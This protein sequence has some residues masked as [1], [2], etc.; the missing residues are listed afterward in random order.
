MRPISKES[1]YQDSM[2]KMLLS[3]CADTDILVAFDRTLK[4][5]DI[6]DTSISKWLSVIF[7]KMSYGAST[8]PVLYIACCTRGD[9]E[10]YELVRLVDFVRSLFLDETQPD[11]LKRIPVFDFSEDDQ[12]QIGVVLPRDI[13]SGD[14]YDL[15]D[16]TKAR[17]LTI[18]LWYPTN[19][20]L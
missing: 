8:M 4:N 7:G 18:Q 19:D 17:L 11:G 9:A 5:P 2:K 16:Q 10:Q 15:A 13:A 20:A 12:P 14:T 6:S 1:N 3:A